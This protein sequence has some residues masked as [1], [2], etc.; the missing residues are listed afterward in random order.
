MRAKLQVVGSFVVW[1]PEVVLLAIATWPPRGCAAVLPSGWVNSI[2]ALHCAVSRLRVVRCSLESVRLALGLVYAAVG[3]L[4]ERL[5]DL[6]VL[7]AAGTGSHRRG[8][9]NRRRR[10]DVRSH[11]ASAV[12]LKLLKKTSRWGSWASRVVGLVNNDRADQMRRQ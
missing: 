5:N 6:E 1:R 11:G 10:A 3:A 9:G 2:T 8:L 12:R 7:Q 4:A